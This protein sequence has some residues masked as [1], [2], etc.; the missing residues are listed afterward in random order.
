MPRFAP[1]PKVKSAVIIQRAASEGYRGTPPWEV[2]DPHLSAGEA[3]HDSAGKEDAREYHEHAAP[4]NQGEKT[5]GNKG[6]GKDGDGAPVFVYRDR[7]PSLF[8]VIT[9]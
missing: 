7:L 4:G 3:K 5:D 2:L 9:P 1:T 8:R 6:C